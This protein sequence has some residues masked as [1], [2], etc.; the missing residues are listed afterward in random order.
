MIPAETTVCG[1]LSLGSD[2]TTR[3]AVR[4]TPKAARSR[5]EGL[6]DT[7]DGGQML[8]VSVT[9]VPEN[10]KANGALIAL[11]AKSWHRPK[12]AFTL[13]RGQTDRNKILT[14]AVPFVAL[15]LQ[16]QQQGILPDEPSTTD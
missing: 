6:T 4:L 5:I 12:S 10:G 1:P 9:A 2:G 14:V 13:L 7:A 8:K 11:L 15:R 16:L 3:L